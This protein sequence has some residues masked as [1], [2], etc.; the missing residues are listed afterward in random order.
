MGHVQR[1]VVINAPAEEV[2]RLMTEASRYGEW[3]PGWAGL[4][5]GPATVSEGDTLRWR[6][7]GH[8]LTFRFRSTIAEVDPPRRL[9]EE[10][11]SRIVRGTVTKTVVQQKRR[12]QL[13]WTFNYRVPGGPFGVVVDWVIAHRVA[14]RLV[15]RSLSNAKQVLETPKKATTTARS[16]RRQTA[17]R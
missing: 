8:R 10:I 9:R 2:F 12:A 16:Y 1:S 5:E 15:E 11:R 14:S 13:S 3:V 6:L 7:Y 17:V 4:D